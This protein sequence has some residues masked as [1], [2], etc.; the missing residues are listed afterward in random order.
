MN[1]VIRRVVGDGMHSPQMA[2]R[3]AAEGAQPGDRMTPDELR[4]SMAREYVEIEQQVKQLNL[5]FF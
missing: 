2:Q 5:K 3:L 1:A 4:A